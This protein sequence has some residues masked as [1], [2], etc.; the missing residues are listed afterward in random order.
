MK[1]KSSYRQNHQTNH[2]TSI[3]EVVLHDIRCVNASKYLSQLG[4]MKIGRT[5]KTI[6][7]F[8][9]YKN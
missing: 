5:E 4:L 6:N 9:T 2:Q 1:T 7:N 8:P 3:Q